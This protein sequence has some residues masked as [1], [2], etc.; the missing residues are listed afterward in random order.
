MTYDEFMDKECVEL[1]D[2]LNSLE[3]VET[4]E[5]CC[6]HFRKKYRIY[7]KLSSWYSLSLLARAFDI[8]YSSGKWRIAIG[9][10]DTPSPIIGTTVFMLESAVVFKTQKR[11]DKYIKE[12]I[13]NIVYW[14]GREYEKHLK[15]E[16]QS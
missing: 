5:S 15:G 3:G 6:G 11:M 12:A 14:K 16:E 9:S 10:T 13:N 8:R 7:F 2:A 4:F 1:C